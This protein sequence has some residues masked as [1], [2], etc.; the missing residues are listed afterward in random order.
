MRRSWA[1]GCSALLVP[2][3]VCGIVAL[4]PGRAEVRAVVAVACDS[5]NAS[6]TPASPAVYGTPVSISAVAGTC[7]A[8][9]FEFWILRPGTQVWKLAQA[10]SSDSSYEWDTASLA[11]GTYRFSIWARDAAS[12]G[13]AS[14]VL[15]SW[16]VYTT[17][18]YT[19]TRPAVATPCTSVSAS[20]APPEPQAPGTVI[21]I[22]AVPVGC[23]N[24]RY[25]F[26]TREERSM[27]WRLAQAYSISDT[28][29]WDT[30]GVTGTGPAGGTHYFSI[31]VRDASSAGTAGNVL[32]TW[33]AYTP[34]NYFVTSTPCN[35]VTATPAPGSPALVGTTVTF[36]ASAVSSCPN[37]LFEFWL[38]A[39]G[40]QTWQRARAYGPDPVF[41]WLTAGKKKGTWSVIVMDR[42]RTSAGAGGGNPVTAWDQF[43][44][45][46]YTLI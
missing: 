24:P 7:P 3:V 28:Y 1:S 2:V 32:G 20:A 40:T 14:N 8:P 5:V 22:T 23:A 42:D 45:F 33:D 38:L 39:P 12:P 25:E 13:V 36:T 27:T 34:F 16:D 10:Y 15:G 9:T 31:W 29:T 41:T 43:Y 6:A 21:A 17:A 11:T 18:Q 37:P 30:T 26:W 46:Y 44:F 4:G 35:D 19:L